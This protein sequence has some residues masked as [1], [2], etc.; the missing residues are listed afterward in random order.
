MRI[1]LFQCVQSRSIDMSSVVV[2]VITQT[3]EIF[4]MNILDIAVECVC[5]RDLIPTCKE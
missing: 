5:N 3:G 2:F 4:E 1:M